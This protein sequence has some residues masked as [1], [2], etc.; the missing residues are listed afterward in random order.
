MARVFSDEAGLAKRMLGPLER[1][2]YRLGGVRA[3]EDM[4]WERYAGSVLVF[5]VVGIL[6]V[7]GLQRL[8]GLLPLNPA[9]LPGAAPELSFNTAV[10]FGTNTNWQAYG[11]ETTLSYLTQMLGLAVQNFV[12]AATGIAVLIALI[13]GFSRRAA[14]G[15]GNFWVDMTRSVLYVLLPLSFVLALLL[16]SQGVVQ[17]FAGPAVARVLDP[18]TAEGE[19]FAHQI[20]SLGPAA[21]QIAIKQ[22]GRRWLP[23]A[24]SRRSARRVRVEGGSSRNRGEPRVSS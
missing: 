2:I 1:L 9:E 19:T 15:V 13:R 3:D 12:S 14:A 24:R 6:V 20:L 22:L 11:G 4:G 10:S 7:Y 8:Q 16:V 21:S 17:T 23:A 18:V 5:N